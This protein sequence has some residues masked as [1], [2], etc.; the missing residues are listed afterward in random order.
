MSDGGNW[1]ELFQAAEQMQLH[2]VRD[3]LRA[4]G[5]TNKI[6]V[7]HEQQA[8]PRDRCE[9]PHPRTSAARQERL[10]LSQPPLQF[11][12]FTGLVH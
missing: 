8:H 4:M 2:G 7:P 1:K 5:A 11:L 10:S 3:Q 12:W 6:G 9:K